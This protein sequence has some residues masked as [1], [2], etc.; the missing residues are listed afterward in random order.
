LPFGI[1]A[2]VGG[3][4]N[5]IMGRAVAANA[6]E[7]FGPM[8]DTSPGE[9]KAPAADNASMAHNTLEGTNLGS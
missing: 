8:P 3:G 5:L 9:L 2:V 4:G 6:K 7:A 1:G